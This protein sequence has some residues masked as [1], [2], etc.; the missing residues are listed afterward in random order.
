MA[1]FY[2]GPPLAIDRHVQRRA[3]SLIFVVIA[4]AALE[5]LSLPAATL[6]AVLMF[7]AVLTWFVRQ[8]ARDLG[9]WETEYQRVPRVAI[10][11][12]S[13]RVSDVRN[14]RYRTVEDVVPAY[15]DAVY[16]LD[17]LTRVDLIC[18]YWS[19][20]H[21]AHVFLSFGF[22]D[23]RHL[24]VSVETRRRRDQAY[25]V[26]AGFFRHYQLIFVVADERDL[27]GVRTDVRREDVYLYRRSRSSTTRPSTTARPTSSP[28]SM[29]ACPRAS[30]WGWTGGSCSAAMSTNSAMR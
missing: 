11:G 24:A 22:A 19:G 9:G 28:S 3:T 23:G 16:N 7:A 6:L 4:L 21:I 27:I 14:F 13:V 17:S 25:S 15:Y 26:I 29:V 12:S 8:R 20:R 2:S 18:S 1:V 10:E 30:G 5:L